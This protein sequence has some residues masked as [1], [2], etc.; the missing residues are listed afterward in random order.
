MNSQLLQK[1]YEAAGEAFVLTDE[2][3][4]RH[5]SFRIGGN[6]D[7][8]V[9]PTDAES[10][11][12]TI[13]CAKEADC[14]YTVI[15]NGTNLLVGDL[16]YRGIVIQICK[17]YPGCEV[18]GESLYV[19]AG[20]LLTQ[21]SRA[22]ERESLTGLEFASGIPGTIG[23]ALVMNAGAYGGEMKDV[24]RQVTVLGPDGEKKVILGDQ[25]RFSYR[26]SRISAEQ[27][28]VLEAVIDLE[29]GDREAIHA[30]MEELREKRTSKQP[31]DVP[32][33]GS[34]FKRPDGYFAGKLIMDAGLRGY[35]VGG[36]M[37]SEKH[38]GF[39]V[40]AGE[41]TALDVVRLME[42]VQRT[43]MERFGVLL[44]PEVRKIGEF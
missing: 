14:P 7:Y 4:S 23:G 41:A 39:V 26:S 9:T 35:R 15:G 2:P 36:A 17:N 33:A 20:T 1:L 22:A 34:T 37:V 8:F 18:R 27:E 21:V 29:R 3:M 28:I 12:R 30:R 19:K 44:E 43:V 25:M 24:V 31:L 40:N 6:A 42:D 32:S 10:L 13:R 38:C 11:V 16:G 5:T